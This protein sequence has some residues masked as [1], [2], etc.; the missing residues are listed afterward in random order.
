MNIPHDIADLLSK[1]PNFRVQLALNNRFRE[2]LDLNLDTFSYR[3][4]WSRKC[5]ASDITKIPF[6]RNTVTLPP[7]MSFEE[8]AK[9]AAF[10]NEIRKVTDNEIA[11]TKNNLTFK[12]TNK[13][14]RKTRNF[15]EQN[16]LAVVPS[17]KTNRLVVTSKDA[18][19]NRVFSILE[20]KET[21]EPL[22]KSR[23]KQLEK[24]ANTLIKNVS[25]DKFN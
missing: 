9:L 14:I 22:K 6:G 13:T 10:K 4:R 12:N 5:K 25:K 15:L 21:Y 17:D 11:K 18:F 19:K 1:G 3:L 8:E 23:Q 16:T 7:K 24:Q 2:R 20:D